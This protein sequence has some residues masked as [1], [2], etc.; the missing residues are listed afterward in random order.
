MIGIARNLTRDQ[1]EAKIHIIE[2]A[3]KETQPLRGPIM[4]EDVSK[5]VLFLASDDS[6]F[7]TGQNLVVDGGVTGGK[8]WRDYQKGTNSLRE[9]LE[10][11]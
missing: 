4:P 10:G 1:A 9:A 2:T 8:M 7:I 5:A 3:F 6:K 11:Y